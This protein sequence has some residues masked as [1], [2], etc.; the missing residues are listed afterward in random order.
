MYVVVGLT[1]LVV[2][3]GVGGWVGYLIGWDDA[4]YYSN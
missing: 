1:C 2:G 3:L 4:D